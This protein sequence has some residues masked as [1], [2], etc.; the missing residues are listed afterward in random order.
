M[1]GAW[2]YTLLTGKGAMLVIGA[3]MM[4]SVPLRRLSRSRG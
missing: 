4:L 1:L 2:G 3:M